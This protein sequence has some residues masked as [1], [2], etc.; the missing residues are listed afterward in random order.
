MAALLERF[1]TDVYHIEYRGI[2][3]N[4]LMHGVVALVGLGAA[5][6]RVESFVHSY[7]KHLDPVPKISEN[8]QVT[9]ENLMTFAGKRSNF[10]ELVKFFTNEL[11]SLRMRKSNA[12]QNPLSLLLQRHVPSL[13]D[14]G[15]GAAAFHPL[16]HIGYGLMQNTSGDFIA[17]PRDV[18]D[19]LSYMVFSYRR[20]IG[21]KSSAAIAES[22]IK[23][24]DISSDSGHWQSEFGISDLSDAL[25]AVVSDFRSGQRVQKVFKQLADLAA[26]PEYD[27]MEPASS[28]E[29][30]TAAMG[31]NMQDC[32]DSCTEAAMKRLHSQFEAKYGIMKETC[33]SFITYTMK[34][35][36]DGAI[37]LYA[38]SSNGDDFFLLHG[39]TSVW[40]LRRMLQYFDSNIEK[41]Q[42]LV[43]YVKALLATYVTQGMPTLMG[44]SKWTESLPSWTDIIKKTVDSSVD[45]HEYKVV[46]TCHEAERV[47]GSPPS[48]LYRLTA[49]QKMRFIP[50]PCV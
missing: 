15:I 30:G 10:L 8:V 48:Q 7:I 33:P 11:E 23:E 1:G 4:H 2:Y 27:S 24:L 19:G 37:A 3:S 46:Y 17:S 34:A 16:I 20:A 13:A 21:G 32:L 12:S 49:A 22:I 26:S 45:E 14:G 43:A 38:Q 44:A 6:A 31:D 29:R 9:A 36:V 42:I 18:I 35:I 41:I 47:Y 40:A 50:W 28:F 39:V 25:L 5:E